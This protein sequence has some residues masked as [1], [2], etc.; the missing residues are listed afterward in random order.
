MRGCTPA[1]LEMSYNSLPGTTL[2][3]KP[4]HNQ[5]AYDLTD[6]TL[7]NI[8]R[9]IPSISSGVRVRLQPLLKP[10]RMACMHANLKSTTA[11]LVVALSCL[12]T[13]LVPGQGLSRLSCFDVGL[14]LQDTAS[15]STSPRVVYREYSKSP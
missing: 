7:N 12:T 3:L 11:V 8:V 14:S 4:S 15:R 2:P 10:T 5:T 13:T 9:I 1:Q 6:L